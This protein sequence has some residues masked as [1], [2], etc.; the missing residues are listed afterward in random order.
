MRLLSVAIVFCLSVVNVLGETLDSYVGTWEYRQRNS[1]TKTGYDD[2]GEKL[3]FSKRNGILEGIYFG[4]QRE[5]EHGL[6]YTV[7]KV[8]N[9][10]VTAD[11]GISFVV[12]ERDLFSE[13]P[14]SL[15]EAAEKKNER[16]GLTRNEL[17]M[18][19][20]V[21]KGRLLLECISRHYECPDKLMSFDKG[22]W[23]GN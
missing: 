15:A 17:K 9:V 21:E 7:V 8:K 20:K 3:Q 11:G 6:F 2:E 1:G 22:K 16:A 23:S 14:T 4:L 10:K 12:P 19:G 5:G 13:R 18:Q